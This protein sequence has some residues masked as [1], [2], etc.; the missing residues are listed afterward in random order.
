VLTDAGW[1]AIREAAPR[2]VQSVRRR[3]LDALDPE[4]Q[5][6]FGALAEVVVAALRLQ[7]AVGPDEDD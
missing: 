1:R 4:Q 5:A 2:H 3:F 7:D 6:Q